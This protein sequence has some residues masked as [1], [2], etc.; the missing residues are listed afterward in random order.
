MVC[1]NYRYGDSCGLGDVLHE[2][3]CPAHGE[4]KKVLGEITIDGIMTV[5]FKPQVPDAF[6]NG[7]FSSEDE[8]LVGSYVLCHELPVKTKRFT[9]H[10]WSV[11]LRP[12]SNAGNAQFLTQSISKTCSALGRSVGFHVSIRRNS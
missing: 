10:C 6:S 12:A 2:D 9:G 1:V 8:M 7:M 4:A 11:S 3:D 5:F